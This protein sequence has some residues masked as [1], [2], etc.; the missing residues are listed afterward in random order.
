[1]PVGW[2]SSPE[3]PGT[4]YAIKQYIKFFENQGY[5]VELTYSSG[6]WRATARSEHYSFV[7]SR[8]ESIDGALHSAYK[9]VK[10]SWTTFD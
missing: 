8:N 1:M 3:V 7:G 9:M 2:G 10:K 5:S 4:Q 6:L